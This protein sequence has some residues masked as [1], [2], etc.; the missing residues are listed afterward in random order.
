MARIET[1][2][3]AREIRYSDFTTDFDTNPITGNLARLSNE[4][5]IK[6][7]LKNRVLTSKGERFYHATYGSNVKKSLFD[8]SGPETAD[9]LKT[10]VEKCLRE[11]P[12]I[13]L[14][15][16]Q[17]FDRSDNNGYQIIVFFSLINIPEIINLEFT[18]QRAR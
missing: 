3:E 11:E 1:S 13:T 8:L 2:K 17:V 6:E 18:L 12:R 10:S 4:E 5:S 9:D 7:A 16:V 15:G 14:K